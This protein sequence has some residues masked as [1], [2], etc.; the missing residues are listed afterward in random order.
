MPSTPTPRTRD[1]KA[2]EAALISAVGRVIARQG[3][4][5]LGINALAREAGVDKVLIYRYF[6]DLPA[7]VRAYADS[8]EFWPSV[9]ELTGDSLEDL[10]E[11][12]LAERFRRVAGNF[13]RALRSRPVTLEVLAWAMVERSELIDILSDDRADQAA[14]LLAHLGSDY[15]GTQDLDAL[16][17]IVASAIHYLAI[18]ARKHQ[19]FL[20]LDLTSEDGWQRI[21]DTIVQLF[22]LF[23]HADNSQQPATRKARA[24][25]AT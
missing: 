25:I 16:I 18:R 17:G 13:T 19:A 12:P 11:L 2:S 3:F 14:Q 4:A 6:G 9:E 23:L 5:S 10:M 1:R 15:Q 21:E 20:K 8:R 22:T 24:K 7:L